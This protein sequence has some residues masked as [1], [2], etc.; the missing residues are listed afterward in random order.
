MQ[1]L[2]ASFLNSVQIWTILRV[3]GHASSCEK[4][5]MD[6]VQ[7]FDQYANILTMTVLHVH[8]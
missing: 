4:L 2:V 1:V 6:T 5:Y 3:C 8:V 7:F